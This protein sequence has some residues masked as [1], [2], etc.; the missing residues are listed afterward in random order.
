M[1]DSRANPK[2]PG[3]V[4]VT[5][6]PSRVPLWLAPVVFVAVRVSRSVT[7]RRELACDLLSST[8][9]SISRYFNGIVSPVAI[10]NSR[11]LFPYLVSQ[12][13]ATFCFKYFIP[14]LD[15]LIRRISYMELVNRSTGNSYRAKTRLTTFR[16]TSSVTRT[17]RRKSK[18]RS[19]GCPLLSLRLRFVPVWYRTGQETAAAAH[20]HRLL[21]AQRTVA[22]LHRWQMLSWWRMLHTGRERHVHVRAVSRRS[23]Q[24]GEIDVGRFQLQSRRFVGRWRQ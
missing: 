10:E 18:E 5:G 6:P 23:V 9:C 15:S 22:W 19:P 20:C 4:H 3:G 2:T 17:T 13:M 12:W 7:I 14:R 11:F 21:E 16:T 24:L 8:R 1:E